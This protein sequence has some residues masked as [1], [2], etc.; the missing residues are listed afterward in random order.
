[1]VRLLL[2]KSADPTAVANA[3]IDTEGLNITVKHWLNVATSAPPPAREDLV[4]LAKAPPMH[5]M[6]EL[7]YALVGQRGALKM[8]ENAMAG[9]FAKPRG[10][11]RGKLLRKPLVMLMTGLPGQS[12]SN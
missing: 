12:T 1:M 9:W 11:E 7:K 2:S 6:H 10:F 8:F 5:K 3:G 4:F